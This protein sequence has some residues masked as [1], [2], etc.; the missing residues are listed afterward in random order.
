MSEEPYTP[1]DEIC[2]T[3]VSDMARPDISYTEVSKMLGEMKKIKVN[4]TWI[5]HAAMY[6]KWIFETEFGTE[7]TFRILIEPNPKQ[8]PNCINVYLDGD[9]LLSRSRWKNFTSVQAASIKEGIA[10]ET[11]YINGVVGIWTAF[12]CDRH[13]NRF[14]VSVLW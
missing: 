14:F 1:E 9:G 12:A 3:F 10:Y 4:D 11:A 8:D 2:K 7:Y 6:S 13:T 5:F